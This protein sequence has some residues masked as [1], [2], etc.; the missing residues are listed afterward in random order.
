[1]S[2]QWAGPILALATFATIAAGHMLVRRLQARYNT[3]PAPFFF[4]LGC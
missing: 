4:A 2:V 3:R 1:M